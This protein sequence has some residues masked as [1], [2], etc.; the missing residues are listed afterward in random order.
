MQ[1]KKEFFHAVNINADSLGHKDRDERIPCE[2]IEGLLDRHLLALNGKKVNHLETC[3]GEKACSC[4]SDAGAESGGGKV[5]LVVLIDASGSMGGA[6]KS[7]SLAAAKAI[8]LAKERCPSDL[9]VAYMGVEGMWGGTNFT[10]NHLSYLQSIRP[11]STIYAANTN[12]VGYRPEQGANAIQDLSDYY[13]WREGACRAIFYI[14]DEEL[15]SISPLSD[16]ANETAATNAAIA[17]AN[18]RQV[19]VFANHLNYQGRAPQIIQNYKDLCANTGGAYYE[20]A[21]PNA[22]EYVKM[23]SEIICKACGSKCKS[24]PVPDIHPCISITW[25]DSDCDCI[26]TDDFEVM[27]ITVCNCY[28][29]VIFKDFS[30]GYINVTDASGGTVPTLP[31]G[32]LSV[33]ALP[34]GPFCFGDI[35]PCVEGKP[36]CKSRQFVL[37]TRGAKAGKYNVKIGAIC[38]D[39]CF[40]YDTDACFEMTLCK[41]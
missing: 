33:Q 41:S 35:G 29:N 24:I 15:D 14:S 11:P 40:H 39:A 27:H 1:S 38:F 21:A 37:S 5:D 12:F 13:D 22:D 23:L 36:T 19:T 18:L 2:K 7:V 4:G 16:F 17:A 20:S 25:G 3:K 6:A 30:I 34:I 32:S 28:S 9:R 8:E 31:D 26:E 10:T